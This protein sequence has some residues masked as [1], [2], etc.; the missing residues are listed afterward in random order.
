MILHFSR[1][2]LGV[3]R[4]CGQGDLSPRKRR[5]SEIIDE[6]RSLI[7]EVRGSQTSSRKEEL[8]YHRKRRKCGKVEP[9]RGL[10]SSHTGEGENL[11]NREEQVW[12]HEER[13]ESGINE[14]G[15]SLAAQRYHG[16]GHLRG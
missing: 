8:Q 4:F 14:E 7:I 9:R 11:T 5:K 12:H 6:V 15:R 16:F 13:K 10:R 2:I 1:I 3:F